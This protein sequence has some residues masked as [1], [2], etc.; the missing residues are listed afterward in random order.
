MK[1]IGRN[2]DSIESFDNYRQNVIEEFQA[3]SIWHRQ[4]ITQGAYWNRIDKDLACQYLRDERWFF[5]F[6]YHDEIKLI[7]HGVNPDYETS[8][9]SI[10]FGTPKK[11]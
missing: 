1:I 8:G 6:K 11:R 3:E 4:R 7:D 2:I 10:G 9:G 5:R